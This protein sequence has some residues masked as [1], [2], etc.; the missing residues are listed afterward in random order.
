[1]ALFSEENAADLCINTLGLQDNY[2]IE[3]FEER[4]QLILTALVACCPQISAP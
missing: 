1:M 2:D 3:R 4:R